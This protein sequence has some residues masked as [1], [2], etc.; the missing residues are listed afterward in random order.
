[1]R[2]QQGAANLMQPSVNSRL[3]R[4]LESSG[5]S[6]EVNVEKAVEAQEQYDRVRDEL[7]QVRG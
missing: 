2:V 5:Y 4:Q 7:A 3:H 6:S 1:M